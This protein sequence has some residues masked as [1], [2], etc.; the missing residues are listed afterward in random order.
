VAVQSP[1]L[2]LRALRGTYADQ[3]W[4]AHRG[5]AFLPDCSSVFAVMSPNG[6]SPRSGFVGYYPHSISGGSWSHVHWGAR[7]EEGRG[8]YPR[9]RSL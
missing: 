9:R 5:F 1:V 7:R 6:D 8:T 4:R 3:S 2:L